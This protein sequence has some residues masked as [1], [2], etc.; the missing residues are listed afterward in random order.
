VDIA[1]VPE[2]GFVSAEE[3]ERWGSAAGFTPASFTKGSVN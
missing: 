1:R 3:L 2:G